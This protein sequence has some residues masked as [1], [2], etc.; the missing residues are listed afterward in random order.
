[1]DIKLCITFIYRS[2]VRFSHENLRKGLG[3]ISKGTM[4]PQK[5]HANHRRGGRVYFPPLWMA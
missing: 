5:L 4:T 3:K 2:T 1:M